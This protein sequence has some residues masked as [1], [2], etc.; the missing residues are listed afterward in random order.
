[1]RVH[2]EVSNT[3]LSLSGLVQGAALKNAARS[4]FVLNQ[5]PR[6]YVP[7]SE[8]TLCSHTIHPLFTS[9]TEMDACPSRRLIGSVMP[10]LHS[11][12][13]GSLFLLGFTVAAFSERHME[14]VVEAHGASFDLAG[15]YLENTH[16][17]N[18]FSTS[19]LLVNP[20]P[21]RSAPLNPSTSPSIH[22]CRL[23]L[24]AGMHV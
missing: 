5:G 23:N 3:L 16:S 14:F 2:R 6:A 1:M 11:M 13:T 18:N 19:K 15:R 7:K 4:Y 21:P 9:H 12:A 24:S 8:V 22:A 20:M 17:S 10:H